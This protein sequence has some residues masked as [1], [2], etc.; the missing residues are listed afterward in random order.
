MTPIVTIAPTVEPLTV[1]EVRAQCRASSSEDALL[2]RYIKASRMQCE[3]ETDHALITQTLMRVLDAFPANAGAIELGAHPAQAIVSIQYVPFGGSTLTTLASDQYT[4]D[5]YNRP[6]WA[7]PVSSWPQTADV[8]NAVRVTWRA[9]F[10][11]TPASVPEP[12]QIWMLLNCCA[13]Y[14]NRSAI[15]LTGKA[16]MLPDRYWDSYLATYR[17]YCV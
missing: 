16:A 2:A 11:D 4:L 5:Q 17:N 3:A 9:G 7:L 10:G 13:L 14:D 12:M 8:A 15:D 1:D 6:G